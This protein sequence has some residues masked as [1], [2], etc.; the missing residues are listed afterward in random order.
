MKA[1]TK[2]QSKP[3]SKK[4]TF[5]SA[6]AFLE[7]CKALVA[8]T[9]RGNRRIL[10]LALATNAAFALEMYLKCLLSLEQ[11]Q[12]PHGHDL[13]KLFHALSS[14]TQSELT[15]D[16][17]QFQ[18]S[19]PASMAEA[20][21]LGLPTDLEELLK[22]GRNAFADF[23]YAHE[24]IPSGTDFALNGLTYCVQ[25]RILKLQPDWDSALQEEANR[26]EAACRSRRS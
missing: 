24:Q 12:A 22:R 5:V 17:E 21:Q 23:R 15:K 20:H 1:N 14:S 25:Q 19:N 16:H 13:H 10:S 9:R 18:N 2:Q 6:E 11:G 4:L 8:E 7:V 3:D 26:V